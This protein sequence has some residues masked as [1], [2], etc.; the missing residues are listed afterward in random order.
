MSQVP[1]RVLG[2]Q[3]DMPDWR[4]FTANSPHVAELLSELLPLA[5]RAKNVDLREYCSEVTS[6]SEIPSSTRVCVDLIEYC[7]RRVFGQ[8]LELSDF[9]VHQT[10]KRFAQTKGGN[11]LSLRLIW[12]SIVRF[13]APTA[14]VWPHPDQALDVDPDAFAFSMARN[15]SQ[16]IYV[17]LDPPGQST[18]TTLEVLRS[19]LAAGF[20]FVF[21]FPHFTSIS[22]DGEIGFPTTY[23][24]ALGG[25]A[26]MA[27]GYDDSYRLRSDRGCFEVRGHWDK[28]WGNNGYGWLP[29]SYVRKQLAT[30][31][32]TVL[33]PQW[34][35]SGEFL[36]PV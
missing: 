11:P 16:L 14:N 31:F 4:D 19:F 21:G 12:K 24:M 36:R 20:P 27:T 3:P 8:P 2:W 30:D 18:S 1:I 9:F 7:E 5:A 32:W 25:H 34:L 15:Y 28:A 22:A 10:A 17:R 33:H 29:Y 23:D 6:E 35:Q 13:G 26:V